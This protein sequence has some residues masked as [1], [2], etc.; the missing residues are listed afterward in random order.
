M[1][2]K[3]KDLVNQIINFIFV[4]V[5]T[6]PFSYVWFNYYAGQMQTR[7]FRWGHLVMLVLYVILYVAF[8]KIYG[9]FSLATNRI[10]STLFSQA[11]ALLLCNGV[12]YLIMILILRRYHVN[13]IPLGLAYLV[14]LVLLTV[15]TTICH[16]WYFFSFPPYRA[17]VIYDMRVGMEDLIRKY[18]L[19]KEFSVRKVMDIEKCLEDLN[20]LNDL[21]VVFLSGIHSHERN[22][23]MKYCVANNMRCYVI[24]RV[25]DIMLSGAKRTHMFHLEILEVG[26]YDPPLYYTVIKR[27]SDILI[28]LV[29]LIVLSPL[30]LIVALAIKIQ[31]K[32]PI[33]YRQ[34]RLTKDRKRF[35]LTKFRSMCVDAESDGIARLST[36]EG[37][38]RVTSVGR[39]IRRFRID[40][41]PQL[42]SVLK[43]DMSICGP[44]PERPEIAEQ[45][46]KELPEFSLRLQA[47]AGLTGY[48][49]VYGKYNT[50]AYDKLLMDLAYISNP[51]LLYDIRLLFS[52]LKVLI[53]PESTE[54]IERGHIT[55]DVAAKKRKRRKSEKTKAANKD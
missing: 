27:L 45:Y 50:P 1:K 49:Q 55:A 25:G 32:G 13:I 40:E 54:G 2:D 9:G 23:V 29:V 47:K 38:E 34:E 44:R 21:D 26:P 4:V 12:M 43:G 31:D 48:A 14:Q 15:T 17:A 18:G 53:T 5:A 46:E 39:F 33:F 24:P 30:M 37:D 20:V 6:L 42:F 11:L 52:T 28:A 51:S 10:S 36:G 22:I 7:F 3:R 41:L 19:F 35:M 8:G 16:K